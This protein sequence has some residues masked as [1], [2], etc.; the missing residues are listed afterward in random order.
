MN[1]SKSSK[2]HFGRI[3][4]LVV[5]IVIFWVF[6]EIRLYQVQVKNHEYY[7]Q[8]SEQQVEK[9]I[10]EPARRGII[11]DRN[12]VALATNLIHYDLG[13]DK[14][15]LKN[16]TALSK[17]FGKIFKR[18]EGYYINKI[19][20]SNGFLYLE[21]RVSERKKSLLNDVDDPG[22]VI[23]KRYRRK[24]PFAEYCSQLIGF[25]DVDDKGA[26]GIELQYQDKLKGKNGW[27]ILQRDAKSR[28]GYSAE[29][30]KIE[31]IN[32]ADIYLTIDKNFQSIVA[33]N[34]KIGVNKYNAKSGMAVLMKPKTGEILAL[35]AYPAFNPNY[36]STSKPENRR[37][38]FVTDVF[39]PGS[40]FKLFVVAALL[41]EGIKKANDIVYC[42]N[43][44]YKIFD[45][46]IRDSK[47]YGW[48]SVQ[49]VFEN[50]S[51]IG[52]VKLVEN[53]PKNIFYRYLKNF[54]FGSETGVDLLGENSGSLIKPA[55]FSGISKAM[56][57]HGYEISTNAL[58]LTNAY[59][60]VIN[61]GT[62]MRP[63]L[64]DKIVDANNEI[65]ED[66][67]FLK[68][69]QVISEDVS[70]VL[71]QFMVGTVQRGTGKNAQIEGY[72]VGGKTGTAIKLDMKKKRYIK[73][74]YLSSF[75]GFA[76][77]KNPEFVLAI[78]LDEP[79]PKYYGGQSAAP[80]FK[81]IMSHLLKVAPSEGYDEDEYFL[82]VNVNDEIPDLK[83]MHISIAKD[84]LRSRNIDYE[85]SGN[86]EYI[87]SQ[88]I[89][90]DE[91]LL[92]LG[93]P[94]IKDVKMPNLK[95][96]TVR[97]ALKKIDFSKIRVRVEGYGKVVNQTVKAGSH[98]KNS[99]L[100]TLSCKN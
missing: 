22:F 63:Y 87:L 60:S 86:G 39:E 24:Y 14:R 42:E 52:I 95:G 58:Q 12:H 44:M 82:T 98:V 75:I 3:Y 71:K 76:P 99:Q 32:G 46:T 49:R 51:N 81:S 25:T 35:T 72:D 97:E 1:R 85:T 41:Q 50:S 38:S 13:V 37:S 69:R 70:D 21:R 47:K 30:Q 78:F 31:A 34:L 77:Q 67:S 29:H 20:R 53:L 18:S 80:I 56:I 43:G 17:K 55:R 90:D 59:S 7:T 2:I 64:I 93:N 9:K 10:I 62:L 45:H 54:G 92:K 84:V 6:L 5:A 91:V 48:L 26:S 73:G 36:P 94:E 79:Y 89:D 4:Y 23:Q 65:I 16:P 19:K 88:K 40:T 66:N 57:S 11:Y 33:E 74:K 83:G 96:L 15:L 61:G 8:K 100:L 68:I 28:L 27:T